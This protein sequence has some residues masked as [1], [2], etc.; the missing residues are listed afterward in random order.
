MKGLL[1]SM[2][3]NWKD[4]HEDASLQVLVPP[5]QLEQIEAHFRAKAT[6]L[7]NQGL[8]VK[9]FPGIKKGF[10][11]QPGD[12]SYKIS[13]SDEAFLFFI[14]EHFKPKTVEFLFADSNQS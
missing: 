5:E 1:G 7:M 9:S 2:V 3:R 10:E 11:I 4:S 14:K 12:G 13:M 8:E 6:D